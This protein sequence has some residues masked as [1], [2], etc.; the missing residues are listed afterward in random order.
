MPW[1][2]P[3]F[4]KLLQPIYCCR[5]V[6]RSSWS[7]FNH[8][9]IIQDVKYSKSDLPGRLHFCPHND[10]HHPH[11]SKLGNIFLRKHI[12]ICPMAYLGKLAE[13]AGGLSLVLGLFTRILCFPVIIT[14]FVVTFIMGDGNI[15][16]ESF[17]LL[18]QAIL[19]LSIGAG[20]WSLDERIMGRNGQNQLFKPGFLSY[21]S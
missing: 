19:F 9:I 4:T 21:L 10:R 16:G 17:L 8:L 14:M 2:L 1:I 20:P 11:Q 18:L 5:R 12:R 15:S 6:G 3:D 7:K 13:L